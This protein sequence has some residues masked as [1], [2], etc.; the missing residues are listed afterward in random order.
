MLNDGFGVLEMRQ[1]CRHTD[2]GDAVW[3]PAFA[4]TTFPAKAGTTF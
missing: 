3:V 4:G 2:V 1:C